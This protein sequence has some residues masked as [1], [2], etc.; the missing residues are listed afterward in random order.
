MRRHIGSI[1]RSTLVCQILVSLRYLLGEIP[2]G[3]PRLIIGTG[4]HGSLPVMAEVVERAA[5]G[6]IDLVAVPTEQACQLISGLECSLTRVSPGCTVQVGEVRRDRKLP[7]ISRTTPVRRSTRW[8]ADLNSGIHRSQFG[9]ADA[10]AHKTGYVA[11]VTVEVRWPHA[12]AADAS[13]AA[14]FRAAL[15]DERHTATTALG[16]AKT[17][18]RACIERPELVGLRGMARARCQVRELEHQV[19]ELDRMIAALDQRYSPSWTDGR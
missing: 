3:G 12:N 9:C 4:A 14:Y 17:R 6:D 7:R 11:T 8:R 5:R 16:Q 10:A 18:L 2:W 13:Q 1:I 19:H 15:T